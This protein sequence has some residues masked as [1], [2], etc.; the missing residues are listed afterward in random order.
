MQDIDSIGSEGEEN[1]ES[2]SITQI[3]MVPIEESR[4]LK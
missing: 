2:G 1:F 4:I 3:E